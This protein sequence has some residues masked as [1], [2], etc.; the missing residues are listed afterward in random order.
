MKKV[1]GLFFISEHLREE[2][3]GDLLYRF[4]K[5]VKK[6][7]R[8]RA[9]IRLTINT[10]KFFRPGILFRRSPYKK[11]YAPYMFK[12]YFVIAF[13]N[14]MAHKTNSGI[15]MLSLI[16]GITSAL[17][18]TYVIRY[19]LSFD[20]FHTNADRIYRIH[21]ENET[22][23][24]SRGSGI[25]YPVADAFRAEVTAIER[26]TGVQ[27]YGGAQVDVET[28]GDLRK[29]KETKGLAFIDTEFFNVFDFHGTGF[30]WIS[31]NPEKA[32]SDP[33]SVVLTESA[34]KKYFGSTDPLGK[35]L[36]LEGQLD[37]KVTGVVSDFPTNTDLPFTMLVSYTTLYEINGSE[38]MKDD[39]M[40]INHEQQAY[41]V[42][43]EN[44]SVVQVEQQFDKVHATHVSKE[45]AAER[46]Y[47]LQPLTNVHKDAKLSNFN[48]RTVDETALWIMA[49]TGL[50]LLSV[51][52]INYINIATAQS[53]LR[54]REIGVR[55]VLGG[56]RKQLVLQ[57]LS[58]T[59]IL[60]LISCVFSLFAAELALVSLTSLTNTVVIDHLF[61][62]PFILSI[63]AALILVI[64]LMAGFYPAFVVSAYG[65]TTALKGLIGNNVSGAYLRRTLVVAQFAVTQAFLIGAFIVINQL[66][67]SRSMDLGFDKDMIVNIAIL[68]N[69]LTNTEKLRDMV[70]TIPN[71][72]T[73]A[74]S[75]TL[76]GGQARSHWYTGVRK[77]E[78]PKESEIGTEYQAID[79]AF[80]GLYDIDVVAGR[81]FVNSDSLRAVI[82]N[83][84]LAGKLGFKASAE[85]IGSSIKLD[86]NDYT[87]VGI[88]EDFHN[89]STR[90]VVGNMAFV[91]KQNFYLMASLKLNANIE[92]MQEVLVDLE[93]VWSVVYPDMMFDYDFFDENIENY[94]RQE[95]KLS[96]LLQIFSV[97]FLVIACLGLYGL[98]SFV[99]NRRMKE[100]AV[101][102]VFGAGITNIMTLISKDYVVLI[103]ISFVIA[104]PLSYYFMDQWLQGFA[105]HMPITWWIVVSPGA[106][107]LTIA[108]LT[109]SGKLFRAA[110][111]NPAETLK[112]E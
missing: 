51:G 96:T 111:R 52:C 98:L 5:D 48:N 112:Y 33:F 39:W 87:V 17:I 20:R 104:A 6:F 77:R 54:S 3:E 27:Y 70:A 38:T 108:I 81:N 22:G 64:T 53:A 84:T 85:A 41:I 31:G 28:N 82:I 56:Q 18:M 97:V 92:D 105:Y 24:D 95:K 50:L 14:M 40:S 93:K 13:R 16:V 29:F 71:V 45:T 74:I 94:Y 9:Q 42:I 90:D 37:T 66:Q 110:A 86:G 10:I 62:D 1:K 99:I 100:V 63:L 101:R 79:T 109:L 43:P 107:A 67:Y 83:E 57:F 75:S 19:E 80:F 4:E 44:T 58:E 103:L 7:G 2:I 76:P 61:M 23:F 35:T 30:K 36:R 12:N 102:K 89:G 47:R 59:F 26:I 8:R 72:S 68:N 60:V 46:K 65:I 106:V 49:I 73:M 78:A 32:L 55:K 34:A 11:H 15:N 88:C 25:A 91:V 69:K 21:R